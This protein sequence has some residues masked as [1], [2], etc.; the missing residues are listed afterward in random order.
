MPPD[1]HFEINLFRFLPK[2]VKT[3]ELVYFTRQLATLVMAGLPLL[4][5]LR[6]L[7]DQL[8][9][10]YL[11]EVV[12]EVCQEIEGGTNFS[13]ALSHYPKAFPELF[14][15]MVGAGEQG[16]ML[17]VILKRLAEFLEK[18]QRL[19]EKVRASMIYPAFVM[20]IAIIILVLLMIFVVP[21]FNAMFEELGG[22]LPL[23]TQILIITSN[24]VR[25]FW[26]ILM[27]IPVGIAGLYRWIYSTP[28][29]HYFIDKF[30]LKLPVIGPLMSQVVVARFSRTLGT[31]LSSGVPI[32]S[33][34]DTVRNVVDNEMIA[35]AIQSVR[36]LI[37]E[38]ESVAGPLEKS[39]VFPPLVIKMVLVGEETGQ[40]DKM[41]VQVADSYEGEV[42]V[43]VN[44]LTALLEPFLIVTMGL[45]VGFIVVSMFLPLFSLTRLVGGE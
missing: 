28:E 44:G 1:L 40:L 25:N 39:N 22:A 8:E 24:L 29:G 34:L 37:K 23:P 17:D 9:K 38:G 20:G 12:G 35:R 19:R 41:L 4:K 11:K 43:A 16:G 10:G 3:K 31:L 15:N 6:T 33:A 7:Y 32:L 18:N 21:T 13:T 26:Y 14:V 30:K 45:M 42:D 5:G 36:E 27:F 2:G